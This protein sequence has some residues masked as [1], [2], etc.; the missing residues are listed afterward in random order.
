MYE[1]CIEPMTV[2]EKLMGRTSARNIGDRAKV[3]ERSFNDLAK[4]GWELVSIGQID[5]T[6]RI[7]KSPEL[8][9]VS[10]AVFRRDTDSN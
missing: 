10:V 3:L 9:D 2:D 1:Y 6:G 5:I 7:R 8:R 4:K